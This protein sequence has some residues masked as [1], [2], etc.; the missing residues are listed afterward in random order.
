MVDMLLAIVTAVSLLAWLVREACARPMMWTNV[1]DYISRGQ[2]CPTNGFL[3]QLFPW[4][5]RWLLRIVLVLWLAFVV[6][7]LVV[8]DGDFALVLA[9]L[10]LFTGLIAGIDQLYFAARRKA[11]IHSPIVTEYLSQYTT[12][13]RQKLTHLLA[14]ELPIAEYAKSFFPVLLVVLVLRSFIVEPFQIPSGSMIPT[15]EIGDYILVNKYNYGIRLPVLGT[16]I[17]DVNEP[18]RGDVMVFFPPHDKRYFIKRVIG[19]P[20]DEISYVDKVL[21]VN[22]EVVEQEIIAEW[23]PLY[24][25]TQLA[26]E[27]LDDAR[28]FIHNDLRTYRSNFSL[29]VSPGHYFVMGDNRDN[30]A[31]SRA[32]GLVPEEN[33]VGQ[34]FAIWMHWGSFSELPSFDRVGLIY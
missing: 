24:P 17:I 1:N 2:P 21:S 4:W 25:V 20:G 6:A 28:Y 16:K 15:L 27:R 31:D 18:K 29:L 22:G 26:E 5:S 33:V 3:E 34:A 13:Q 11:Y 19:I 10:T 23:P 12:E 9:V 14:K 8:K 32:W 30:S 7:V